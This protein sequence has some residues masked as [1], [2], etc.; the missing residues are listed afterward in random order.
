MGAGWPAEKK[1]GNQEGAISPS[2]PQPALGDF[3]EMPLA[4]GAGSKIAGAYFIN[5]Y[6]LRLTTREFPPKPH[7]LFFGKW[8]STV[9][10]E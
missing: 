1:S 5:R 3:G 7:F 4:E 8:D 6:S 10:E 9:V 2:L